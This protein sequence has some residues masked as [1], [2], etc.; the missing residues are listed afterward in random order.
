M[1][2]IDGFVN[3]EGVA[4]IARLC[5]KEFNLWKEN[6]VLPI[7][8]GGT[9]VSSIMEFNQKNPMVVKLHDTDGNKELLLSST[10]KMSSTRKENFI[11]DSPWSAS[12][13]TVGT[14]SLPETLFNFE[15]ASFTLKPETRIHDDNNHS[16]Y[17]GWQGGENFTFIIPCDVLKN[18]HDW[19]AKT[20]KYSGKTDRGWGYFTTLN[21]SKGNSG[22]GIKLYMSDKQNGCEVS[23]AV[24]SRDFNSTNWHSAG[25]TKIYGINRIDDMNGTYGK[26]FK[27]RDCM[28]VWC[29][30]GNNAG[31]RRWYYTDGNK[32]LRCIKK[33]YPTEFGD[34]E[35]F[36]EVPEGV[37]PE[38][39]M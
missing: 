28:P 23:I 4:E 29:P 1:A 31:H 3:G 7:E 18:Q 32:T 6:L 15:F 13:I 39:P 20:D 16:S 26:P 37:N 12:D 34:P 24:V 9:G 27:Y 35:Y 5:N 8:S 22:M 11:G 17:D 30:E 14:V 21:L 19:I 25:I 10:S 33:G 2:R 36:E 38:D